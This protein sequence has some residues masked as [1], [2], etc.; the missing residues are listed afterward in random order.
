[1]LKTETE[2]IEYIHQMAKFGKKAGLSNI[3]ALLFELG[4]PQNELK[5]IHVAGTNGKGSVTCMLSNILNKAGYKV[6]MNTSPYIESFNERLQINNVPICAKKLIVH[7]NTVKNAVEKLNKNGIYPIEFEVIAAI[8]FLYFKEEKCDY[9]VLECGLG[10]RFDAT[11]VI[12]SPL[13]SVICS[14][15]LDHTEFLGNTLEEIAFEKAGIIKNNCPVAVYSDN[16]STATDVIKKRALECNCSLFLSDNNFEIISSAINVTKFKLNN[17][18]Y[19]ISLLG[20]H[21]VKNA[22]LVICVCDILNIPYEAVRSGLLSSQWKCRFEVL[23]NEFIIDGAHNF[24]GIK[25]F[26]KSVEKYAESDENVFIIGMLNDKSFEKSA[27]LIS[28]L[29][30]KFI[31]TD[32]PSYRQTDGTKIYESIKKYVPDAIYIKDYKEALKKAVSLK[33][34]SGYVLIAGSLYLAGALRMQ[35][36]KN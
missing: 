21:Q 29:K 23:K 36:N 17:K 11:N 7:T 3:K 6:G 5:Y 31:V 19:E 10:G 33:G 16:E 2:C 15:G 1:M 26:V 28:E 32:V 22:A 24:E 18:E 8:G 27:K 12:E 35:I 9:V 13:V 25:T 20:E 14:L 30:G 4:N 34:K